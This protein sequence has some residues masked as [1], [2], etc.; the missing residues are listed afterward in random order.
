MA[1]KIM[2]HG[3]LQEWVAQEK[4]YFAAE[5]LDYSFVLAGDYGVH[6]PRRDGAGEIRTGAFETFGAGRDG[7]DVSCACHWATSAAASERAGQLITTAYSVT[8][9]AIVVPPES[10]I[11]RPEDLAGVPIG[12]GYHSG[13]HFATL[14]AL[15][16]VLPPGQVK[17]TFQ[18]PPNERLDALLDRQVPAATT[19]GVP[20]YIAEAFGFRKVLDATF[21]IGFL[22]TGSGASKADVEKYLA[23]LRRAQQEIDLHP[24][25]YKHY[26]LRTVPEK[27]RGQ[28]DVR[29]FG[30]G[31][32]IVFLPY[33]REVFAATQEWTEAHEIFPQVPGSPA[34]Y[35]E[36]ALI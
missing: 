19:W 3:R 4:G 18:G 32:R 20:L 30:T 21:M 31:E 24:E 12:V 22:V 25:L 36:A 34:G 29:A 27:Y 17:L 23:A 5:G 9:C 1:L 26:H 16:A 7:A 33:P 13:S 6:S 8:P 2:P 10:P 28:V 14:Q 35:D 11:G 15:E